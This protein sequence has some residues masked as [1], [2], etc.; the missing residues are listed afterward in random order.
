[1]LSLGLLQIW[2]LRLEVFRL[3]ALIAMMELLSLSFFS[4]NTFSEKFFY[5]DPPLFFHIFQIFL[6]MKASSSSSSDCPLKSSLEELATLGALD[7]PLND[8]LDDY[9]F[10]VF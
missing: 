3:F 2:A 6:E 5:L 10:F 8:G 4:L 1:M 9:S 7:G